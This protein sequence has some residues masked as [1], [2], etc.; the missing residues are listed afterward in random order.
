[1]V[2][3][4]TEHSIPALIDGIK[5]CHPWFNPV[6]TT[7][8]GDPYTPSIGVSLVVKYHELMDFVHFLIVDFGFYTFL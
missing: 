1:V 5:I 3:F 2:R 4:C 6:T 7:G 8:V